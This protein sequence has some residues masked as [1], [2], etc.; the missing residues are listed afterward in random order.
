ML[1][2][3][4]CAVNESFM[5]ISASL[6]KLDLHPGYFPVTVGTKS[7]QCLNGVTFPRR[8]ST[9]HRIDPGDTQ[10]GDI[11]SLRHLITGYIAPKLA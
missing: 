3:P 8:I 6:L 1:D 5:V 9:L 2:N 10:L 4:I 11:T 7:N